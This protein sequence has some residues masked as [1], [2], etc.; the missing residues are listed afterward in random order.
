MTC[1]GDGSRALLVLGFESPTT[2]VDE[3]LARG[4]RAVPRARRR[5]GTSATARRDGAVGAWR[6]AFLR[7]PYLRDTLV[8]WA[9]SSDT[10]ETAIT[11]DR[12]PAFHETVTAPTREALRRALRRGDAAASRTSTP[13]A[14]RRTS[15][16][17]RRRAAATSSSSGTR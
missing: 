13:T 5:R 16:S 6:E 14:R 4:A 10:F 15:R 8:R 12:F 1:A 11:W 3:R 9:S 7:A 2:P 17:S